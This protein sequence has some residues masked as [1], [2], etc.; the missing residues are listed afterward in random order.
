MFVFLGANQDVYT[1]GERMAVAGG[2]RATWESTP[3]GSSQ[4]WNELSYS[5]TAH[6]LKRRATRIGDADEFYQKDPKKTRPNRMSADRNSAPES[7]T[8]DS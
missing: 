7:A 8:P 6:R 4:M 1:E 3:A 5:T 2:N